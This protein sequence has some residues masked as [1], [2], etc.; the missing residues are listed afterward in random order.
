MFKFHEKSKHK[1]KAVKISDQNYLVL[2]SAITPHTQ[3]KKKKVVNMA[4][5]F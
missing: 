2:V 1:A 3:K 5:I 4:H